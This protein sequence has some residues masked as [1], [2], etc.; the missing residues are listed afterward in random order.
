MW[1]VETTDVKEITKPEVV[2]LKSVFQ[3]VMFPQYPW[4]TSALCYLINITLTEVNFNDFQCI[5]LIFFIS[6]IRDGG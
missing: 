6:F 1:Q 4:D 5:E 3:A 2:L